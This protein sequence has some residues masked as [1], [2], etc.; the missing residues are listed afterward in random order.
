MPTKENIQRLEALL[1]AAAVL[2]DTKKAV[3]RIEQEIRT[4]NKLLGL[5]GDDEGQADATGEGEGEDEADGEKT[6]DGQTAEEGGNDAMEVER[7]REQSVAVP[8]SAAEGAS[9]RQ[10]RGLHIFCLCG[11]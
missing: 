6:G 5:G 1:D 10:V 2:I 9:R 11:R 7:D 8:D 4:Q 3:D